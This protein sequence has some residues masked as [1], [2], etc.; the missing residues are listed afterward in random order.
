MSTVYDDSMTRADLGVGP[1]GPGPPFCP[2]ILLFCKRVS[3]GT[4]I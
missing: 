2:G 1:G 3:D 4:S